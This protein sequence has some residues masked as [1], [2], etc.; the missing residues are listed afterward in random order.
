MLSDDYGGSRFYAD[1]SLMEG[2]LLGRV[3]VWAV[4]RLFDCMADI[5]VFLV[6]ERLA[7]GVIIAK[8]GAPDKVG[9]LLKLVSYGVAVLLLALNLAQ[10]GL[11]ERFNIQYYVGNLFSVGG[12]NPPDNVGDYLTQSQQVEFSFQVLVFVLSLAVVGRTIMV[13]LQAR[14]EPRVA[15]VSVHHV[16]PQSQLAHN[17]QGP[18]F[19]HR[20]LGALAPPLRLQHGRS[21]DARQSLRCH[22][23][24]QGA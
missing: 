2:L 17:H 20:R 14:G 24:V 11:G 5:F 22:G 4:A 18:Q 3:H 16:P 19:R 6:L 9:K 7:T 10:F 15:N 23:R 12:S 1:R 8:T 21:R 13:K